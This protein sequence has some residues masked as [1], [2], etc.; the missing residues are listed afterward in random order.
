M[1]AD[2]E[3]RAYEKVLSY[4]QMLVV[5][6]PVDSES[7]IN[8][9]ALN[10]DDYVWPHGITPPLH[11]VR[12]RRFRKR[13]S[14]RAIEVVEESV[15]E[16][17]QKDEEAEDTFTGEVLILRR[18]PKVVLTITDLIDVNVDP[19]V[20]DSYY[21]DYDPDAV[22]YRQEANESEVDGSEVYEDP[23]S[24]AQQSDWDGESAFYDDQEGA[25]DYDV[26]EEDEEE[27]YDE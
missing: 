4:V 26:D 27:V 15:E 16:L 9:S 11:H 5:D 17:V 6:E 19:D 20:P 25:G 13:L 8:G 23:G 10:I 2:I 21:I 1:C 24:V 7:A 3:R 12:K 18:W 22:W 14:R